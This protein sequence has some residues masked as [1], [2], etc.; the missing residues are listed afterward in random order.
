[1]GPNNREVG[2]ARNDAWAPDEV[3]ES[4][5]QYSVVPTFDLILESVEGILLVRRRISPYNGLWAL[6]GLRI[7]RGESVA[8]CLARIAFDE[9]GLRINSARG[10]FVNQATVEFRTDSQRQ[11]L[12]TC[13]AFELEIDNVVLNDDHLSSWMFIRDV[14]E[15]PA[16]TGGLYKEHLNRYFE[17]RDAK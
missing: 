6:P 2:G 14:A 9:V 12:S 4:I 5:L 7:F 11:D 3:F 1:M 10:T 17:M 15:I 16:T 8:E 13:Y